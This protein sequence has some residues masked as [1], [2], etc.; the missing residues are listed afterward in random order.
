MKSTKLTLYHNNRC[1]KSRAALEIL[2]RE[3]IPFEVVEYLK[4][5]PTEK[6]LDQLL[7]QLGLEP[8]AII[9]KGEEEYKQ[10]KLDEKP[11][12][13]R[14]EWLKVLHQHP[15]L[16]E[17]PIVSDGKTAVIGRPPEKIT[18]WLNR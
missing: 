11:P 3:K 14:K 12:H 7:L 9:R 10:L 6:T 4:N 1:S 16:I 15:V 8:Q 17:R 18:D 13:T 2:E 5:P